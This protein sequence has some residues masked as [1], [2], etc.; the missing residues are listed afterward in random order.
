[1]RPWNDLVKEWTDAADAGTLI[2]AKHDPNQ[3]HASGL[4]TKVAQDVP[5]SL[6]NLLC[7]GE[8]EIH[9]Y[10]KAPHKN[11]CWV[12][13]PKSGSFSGSL[14]TAFTGSTPLPGGHD[15]LLIAS[16]TITPPHI[17]GER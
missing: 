8:F 1:M 15:R 11:E 10:Q 6:G 3:A 17:M 12:L 13:I 14:P 16:G 9:E 4:H 5:A 2:V 7:S